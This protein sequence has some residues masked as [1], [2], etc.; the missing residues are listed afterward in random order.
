MTLIAEK[1]YELIKCGLVFNHT[2]GRWLA[3]YPWIKD[4]RCLPNNIHFAYA[5]LR[6]TEKILSKD[7]LYAETYQKQIHDMLERKVARRVSDNELR[8][9][10]GPKFY[11][12]H[13]DVLSPQS[14]ST[15]MRVVFNS[16]ARI[17][18]GLSLNDCLA[19]GPCLLNQ[20]LGI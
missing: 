11:I 12:S 14:V 4:P 5:T 16:S 6:S 10:T 3:N 20:L 13:H 8:N 7:P 1:E 19:K 9:Y 18:G 15:P 2:T 17:K